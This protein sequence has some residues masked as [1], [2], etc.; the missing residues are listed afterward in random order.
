MT[1]FISCMG[2]SALAAYSTLQRQKEI[3][4]RKVLGASVM[5]IVKLISTDF[6]KLVMLSCTVVTPIAWWTMDRSFKAI[7]QGKIE[8]RLFLQ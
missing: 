6:I 7:L 5:G 2:L 1:I 8:H 4:V 3:G